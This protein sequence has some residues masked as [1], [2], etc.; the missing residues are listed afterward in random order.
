[1]TG[2]YQLFPD[3]KL[4]IGASGRG[5]IYDLK[6][7]RVFSINQ[8]AV[9]IINYKQA[10]NQGYWKKLEENGLAVLNKTTP[11]QE[12]PPFSRKARIEKPQL[13]F[14]WCEISESCNLHCLHCYGRFGKPEP[15]QPNIVNWKE[16]L[17]QGNIL[18]CH[19]VQFIGGEPLLLKEK[20]FQL[21]DFAYKIGYN[22]VEVFTNGTLITSKIAEYF[23]THKVNVAT[24]LY[25]YVA[26]IHDNIT[27]QIGSFERTTN[28]LKLLKKFSVPTRVAVIAMAQN[29]DTLPE[30]MKY[31]ET[32]GVQIRKPEIVRPTGR[33]QNEDISPRPE[34]IE[35]YVT[36]IRPSFQTTWKSFEEA[37]HW[38]SCWK[39]KVSVTSKGEVLPCIFARNHVAGNVQQNR[40]STIVKNDITS[41]WKVTLNQVEH[42]QACEYRFACHNCR[43]LSE[44]ATGN[45]L[46]RNPRCKYNPYT[47]DWK[48]E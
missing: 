10:D 21:I 20:L 19:R 22:F 24:S 25:S 7:R 12:T 36:R 29:Q 2:E 3:S 15:G 39:G 13:D 38:N 17:Y 27:Q 9:E 1:M 5:A 47:G 8:H 40:L 45:M 4:I 28:G 6:Y 30:T 11:Y 37:H 46:G 34:I 18:G 16:V 31:L 48:G 43:P 41:Y 32:Y 14:I 35:K 42:C 23:A 26:S 44:G 33:G